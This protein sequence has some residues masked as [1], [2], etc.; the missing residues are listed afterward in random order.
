VPVKGTSRSETEIEIS[1]DVRVVREAIIGPGIALRTMA[2]VML[3]TLIVLH[4]T[5]LAPPL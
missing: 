5:A 3:S 1:V 2:A 4:C